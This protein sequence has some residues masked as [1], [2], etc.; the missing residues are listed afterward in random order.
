MADFV[1]LEEI[2]QWLERTR[3]S[4]DAIDEHLQETAK[5][6]VFSRTSRA[7]DQSGWVDADSSPALIRK[8]ISMYIASW[9]YQRTYAES[10]GEG[11]NAYAAKLEAMAESLLKGLEEGTVQLTDVSSIDDTQTQT[12]SYWPNENTGNTQQ[13]DAANTPLGLDQYSE[14]I[15]FTMGAIF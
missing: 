4:V 8:I 14:D 13:Y 3:L 5:E 1:S 6:L 12:P 10:V 7:F 15:K 9:T 11:T 2:Q